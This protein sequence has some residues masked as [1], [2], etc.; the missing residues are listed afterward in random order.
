MAAAV[1]PYQPRQQQL[2]WHNAKK[3]WNLLLCHRR[4]G[5]TVCAVNELIKSALTC[6][7]RAPR[8]L[9]VAPLYKQAKKVAWDYIKYFCRPIPGVKFN[10]SELRADFPTGARIQLGGGDNPDSF[11]GE[12]FDGVV[13]DEYGDMSPKLFTEV[14]RPALSDRKGWALFIG[15]AKGGTIFHDLYED[16]VNDPEWC[17]RVYKASETG[18]IDPEELESARKIMTKDEFDQEYECSWLASIQGAY[19]SDQLSD[20]GEEGRITSIPY[21]K[22][23]PVDTFWDLG[24][25]DATTIWFVQRHGQEIRMIDYLEASG[26]GLDYYVKQLSAK[27]YVYGKHYAPHDIQVRELG[28]GKSR[29]EIAKQLGIKFEVTPNIGVMDGINAARMIFNRV[30]FDEKKC[31]IGLQAL[32]NYRKEWSDKRREFSSKPLHDWSSHAADSFRYMAVNMKDAKKKKELKYKTK[33]A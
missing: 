23:L 26:E 16:V 5:K 30:W 32:R 9:Y 4:F 18:I 19:Y 6:E 29:L 13:L 1:I 11:R 7:L 17:V 14:I 10:E 25:S 33:Y 3:R 20:A 27:G 12:Y 8:F 28:T 22:L 15:S 24:V 21:E 31:K 2:E